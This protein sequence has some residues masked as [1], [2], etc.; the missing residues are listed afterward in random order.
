MLEHFFS[1][2]LFLKSYYNE[3]ILRTLIVV[4][5]RNAMVLYLDDH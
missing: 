2:F 4:D 1:A 5:E 3:T